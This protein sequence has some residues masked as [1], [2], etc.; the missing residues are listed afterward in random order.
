M[1]GETLSNTSGNVFQIQKFCTDDGPGIRTTVFLKGCHMRCAWC[2]NPESHETG[3]TL[4]YNDRLCSFCRRCEAVCPQHCHSF[5][6][7]R[8]HHI[9]RSACRQCGI[10]ENACLYKAIRLCG[11]SMTAGEV[12][13]TVL[14]DRAFYDISHGGM[15]ISGGEPLLQPDFVFA[16]CTLAKENGI[17]TC[18]ETAGAI[19]FSILKR[20][21]PVVDLFLYDIKETDE[22][23]HIR[24]TGISSRLPLENLYRLDEAG[25]T[26]RLRCPIIPGVSD[27]TEHFRQLN[28]LF[29]SLKHATAI[30]LMP[31]HRLG[32]GKS[33]RY[34]ITDTAD[35][36]VP[37]DKQVMGWKKQIH[38][39]YLFTKEEN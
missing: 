15:T 7:D 6:T 9:D 11:K 38:P 33:E 20:M 13:V 2:H 30:Q 4:E 18:I 23:N 36:S 39:E 21:L 14:A 25:A 32:K 26:V 1:T 17:H 34:G 22:T 29:G 3:P 24:Y 19:P 5:G 31:Y 10:C 16:L 37:D 35:F 12:L 27:R 28:A 8:T